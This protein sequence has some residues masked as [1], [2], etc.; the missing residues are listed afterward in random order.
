[1][2]VRRHV[3]A[4][5]YPAIIPDSNSFVTGLLY[6]VE[7]KLDMDRLD[8]FESDEYERTLVFVDKLDD[9]GL[10]IETVEADVYIWTAGAQHLETYDWNFNRFLKEDVQRWANSHSED[11]Q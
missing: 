9:N 7:T 4:K 8:W 6:Y 1:G 10:I 11:L 3:K 5:A 2:Y